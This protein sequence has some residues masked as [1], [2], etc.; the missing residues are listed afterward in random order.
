MQYAPNDPAWLDVVP[1]L[2]LHRRRTLEARLL[3]GVHAIPEIPRALSDDIDNGIVRDLATEFRCSALD[4]AR[5]LLE[6]YDLPMDAAPMDAAPMD[7]VRMDAAPHTPSSADSVTQTSFCLQGTDAEMTLGL[8]LRALLQ[9]Q[10]VGLLRALI[11]RLVAEADRQ[12]IAPRTSRAA[13]R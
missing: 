11:R 1:P 6:W 13:E 10:E 3:A 2:A 8:R 12:P 5:T 9:Q 4:L 7:A